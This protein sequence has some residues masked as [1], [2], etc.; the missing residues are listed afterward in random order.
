MSFKAKRRP[1]RA[2]KPVRLSKNRRPYGPRLGRPTGWHSNENTQATGHSRC[3]SRSTINVMGFSV[4]TTKTSCSG[5]RHSMLRRFWGS[6]FQRGV[7]FFLGSAHCL[8]HAAL[9][10]LGTPLFASPLQLIATHNG[11]ALEVR[12]SLQNKL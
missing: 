4:P 1:K 10:G 9:L 6:V 7:L 12:G 11:R 5:R 8:N 2:E 3:T